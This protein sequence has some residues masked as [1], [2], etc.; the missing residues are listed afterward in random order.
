MSLEPAVAALA[1][2]VVLG[3]ALAGDRGRGL[4]VALVATRRSAGAGALAV[5][6]PP[7]TPWLAAHRGLL[8]LS[9]REVARV[10]KLWTQTIAAPMLSSALFIVVFGL[11]LGGRIRADRR[12]RP[13]S[14]SSSPG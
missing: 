8:A 6:R 3:Q 11:S 4:A 10:L 9:A 2:L 12:R 7:M 1:G 14:S 5:Q 13:T